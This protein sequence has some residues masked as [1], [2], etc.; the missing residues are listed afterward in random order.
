M[1]AELRITLHALER[2]IERVRPG[3]T[4]REAHKDLKAL[5]AVAAP[6]G[7]PEWCRG[8]IPTDTWLVVADSIAFPIHGGAVVTVMTRGGLTDSERAARNVHKSR[9][10]KR[11]RFA[12]VREKS[13]RLRRERKYDDRHRAPDLDVIG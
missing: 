9:K 11:H 13:S 6:S 7:R 5:L 2:Y 4:R 12:K 1:A 8:D 3:F 10:R